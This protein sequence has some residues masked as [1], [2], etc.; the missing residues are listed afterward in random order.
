MNII[1]VISCNKCFPDHFFEKL[2]AEIVSKY[3]QSMSKYLKKSYASVTWRSF[4]CDSPKKKLNLTF[5]LIDPLN[6]YMGI[7]TG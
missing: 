5:L 2:R 6:L 3:L 7:L 4:I 1:I